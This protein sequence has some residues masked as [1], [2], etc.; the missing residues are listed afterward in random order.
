MNIDASF[1]I[2]NSHIICQDYA[3]CSMI[4]D[5]AYIIVSDGCSSSPHTDLGARILTHQLITCLTE[6]MR[7]Q[8]SLF[9]EAL[10]RARKVSQQMQLPQS[11]LDCTILLAEY[12]Q[13]TVKILATGDGV[14]AYYDV[15]DSLSG[16]EMINPSHAPGYLNYWGNKN[17]IDHYQQQD[18]GVLYRRLGS[19]STEHHTSALNIVSLTLSSKN[20]KSVLLCS[21]G[22]SSFPGVS[23]EEILSHLSKFPNTQGSFVQRRLRKFT[24]K[25]CK[26]KSWIHQDDLAVAV[27][28]FT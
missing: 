22:I 4:E 2:G 11:S 7:V 10:L 1:V 8:R 21:D 15:D 25:T 3:Y 13:D 24:R 12:D 26:K 23:V 19:N 14:I 18:Q 5:R 16:I 6:G 9:A 27:M 28:S 20:L 17:R